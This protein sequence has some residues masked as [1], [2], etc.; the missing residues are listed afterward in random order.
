MSRLAELGYPEFERIGKLGV[1]ARSATPKE[2]INRLGV[3]IVRALQIP[4][5]RASL[6]KQEMS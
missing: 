6:F 1:F 5:V 2:L 3:E 4:E